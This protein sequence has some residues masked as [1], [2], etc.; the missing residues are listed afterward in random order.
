[1]AVHAL[2]IPVFSPKGRQRQAWKAQAPA[3]AAHPL[4][5][6]QVRAAAAR[7]CTGTRRRPGSFI[8]LLHPVPALA[9]LGKKK[10]QE[11]KVSRV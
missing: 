10:V 1:M 3:T 5:L 11:N 7:R 8:C 4:W 2:L 6:G 9:R